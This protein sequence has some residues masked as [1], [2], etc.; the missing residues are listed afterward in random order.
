MTETDKNGMVLQQLQA[1]S[2]S[3]SGT[4]A[5]II[6]GAGG[7]SAAFPQSSYSRWTTFQYSD[8]CLAESQ[9]V[10]HTIP[11]SG[12]GSSGTNYGGG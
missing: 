5:D 4:L 10:Y 9:R 2:S 11:S 12:E 7:A 1:V 8:C 3:T 6:A